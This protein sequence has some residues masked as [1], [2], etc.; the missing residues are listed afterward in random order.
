VRLASRPGTRLHL[1]LRTVSGRTATDFDVSDEPV[2]SVGPL[3]DVRVNSISGDIHV[4]RAGST[5]DRR[6]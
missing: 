3:L 2:A 4:G 1:D 6:N 5:S